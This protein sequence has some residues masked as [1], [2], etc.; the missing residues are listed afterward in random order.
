[1]HQRSNLKKLPKAFFPF[2]VNEGTPQSSLY[3][4]SMSCSP[5][6]C[7]YLAGLR[8]WGSPMSSLV[9]KKKRK[10]RHSFSTASPKTDGPTKT[11]QVFSTVPVIQV[12]HGGHS[13]L[14]HLSSLA[15]PNSARDFTT[16]SGPRI[17]AKL[18]S[19][20]SIRGSKEALGGL[21]S[22]TFPAHAL[23]LP[24][25]A[26]PIATPDLQR[27]PRQKVASKVAH[28]NK[29]GL[30]SASLSSRRAFLILSSL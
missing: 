10:A 12:D 16:G 1:V 3:P 27:S 23:P 19:V 14:S 22:P 11:M 2:Q 13:P 29:S 18:A 28:S 25:G 9:S 8:G 7:H 30:V 6:L 20:R 15:S 17:R 26:L 5:S 4:Y 21:P 24:A